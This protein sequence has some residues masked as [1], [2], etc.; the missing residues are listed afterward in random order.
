MIRVTASAAALALANTNRS[1]DLPCNGNGVIASIWRQCAQELSFLDDRPS[2]RV[3]A[4]PG[5]ARNLIGM[6]VKA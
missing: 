4:E 2:A 3:G 1:M 5:E 6:E